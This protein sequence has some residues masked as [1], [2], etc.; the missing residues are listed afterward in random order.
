MGMGAPQRE[1]RIGQAL[2]MLLSPLPGAPPERPEVALGLCHEEPD[3]S[4]RSGYRST[5]RCSAG[6]GS[7]VVDP[8][9]AEPGPN[10]PVDR[11]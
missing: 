6:V 1:N 11:A 9:G 10:E 7:A 5:R 8:T 2:G 4:A 3:R